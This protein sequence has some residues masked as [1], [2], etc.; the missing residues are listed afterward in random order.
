[1]ANGTPTAN[2]VEQAVRVQSLEHIRLQPHLD[3]ACFWI[4][5][6]LKTAAGIA[7]LGLWTGQDLREVFTPLSRTEPTLSAN[8]SNQSLSNL[9]PLLGK[10]NQKRTLGA[11]RFTGETGHS[12]ACEVHQRLNAQRDHQAHH[13][14]DEGLPEITSD[15]LAQIAGLA[16]GEDVLKL[17]LLDPQGDFPTTDQTQEHPGGT[18]R[19]GGKERLVKKAQ[20]EEEI[21]HRG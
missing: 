6:G 13:H 5:A 18:Q 4:T 17:L 16:I 2:A 9:T 20:A 1:M 10:P 19:E 8:S 15:D 11:G 3:R 14:T 21:D 12:T 7:A